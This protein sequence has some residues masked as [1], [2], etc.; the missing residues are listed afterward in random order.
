MKTA[1]ILPTVGDPYILGLWIN[2][3][4]KV[5]GKDV[6]ALYIYVNSGID[7]PVMDYLRSLLEE[8][9]SHVLEFRNIDNH[10]VGIKKCLDV[11]TEDL[12]ML[13][14]DDFY[15][16]HQGAIR[17]LVSKVASGE[18]DCVVSPRGSCS[19]GVQSAVSA[20]FGL[21]G[22]EAA[23]PNFWPCLVI[24]KKET[25]TSTD[26]WYDS[27][28]FP[29]GVFIPE[30][31]WTP[32]APGECG[33]TFVW[34]SIQLRNKCLRFHSENQNRLTTND[35]SKPRFNLP[36]V[37]FGSTSTALNGTLLD[38][39]GARLGV[40]GVI[41]ETGWSLPAIPDEHLREDYERRI[42]LWKLCFNRFPIPS[43]SPAAYFNTDYSN[44]ME[45]M[46]QG[47]ALSPQ[48]IQTF[49][50]IY[51]RILAPCLAL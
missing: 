38:E 44:A 45:R 40:R 10:G 32:S 21:Q 29:P 37:H 13:C 4:K 48:K 35:L 1:A 23:E 15:V 9:G 2:S 39:N 14:E 27:K 18:V 49:M 12:V 51:E 24:A 11:C 3:Y 42:S 26:Q 36:W 30:L 41:K 46:I 50:G 17:S 25:L 8:A 33:D 5:W 22:A 16:L 28:N 6:D 31:Q 47:R 7:Q 19:L 20:H 34:T 43:N